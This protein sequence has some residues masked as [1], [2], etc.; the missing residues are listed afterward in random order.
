MENIQE[1]LNEILQS[2]QFQAIA[3]AVI[4]F[5]TTNFATIIVFGI[6]LVKGKTKE[7]Q[8]RAKQ[9]AEKAQLK[10]EYQDMLNTALDGIYTKIDDIDKK[11]CDKI[12]STEADRKEEIR[13]ESIQIKEAIDETMK[14]L[15]IDQIM[16]E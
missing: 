13:K 1:I 10:Q 3:A 15:N 7:I 14:S 6:K 11:V 16:M 9:E 5:L 2:P 4:T 8:E 12:N